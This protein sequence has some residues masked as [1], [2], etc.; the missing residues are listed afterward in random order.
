[1]VVWL[2]PAVILGIGTVA[3]IQHV[4]ST[5]VEEIEMEFTEDEV[6][7]LRRDF[8]GGLRSLRPEIRCK[9]I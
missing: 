7:L 9:D 8:T 2:I 3:Y 5:I 1:M 6:T 4:L